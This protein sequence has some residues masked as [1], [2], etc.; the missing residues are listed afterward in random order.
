[1]S[2]TECIFYIL[3]YCKHKKYYQTT[4]IR[5]INY[6]PN[7]LQTHLGLDEVYWKVFVFN[8]LE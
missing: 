5:G 6:F 7:Y 4:K 2:L 8:I 3:I 1:M